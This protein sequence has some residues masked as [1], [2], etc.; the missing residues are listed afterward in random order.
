MGRDGVPEA[1]P[2]TPPLGSSDERQPG[3]RVMS[4]L[5][6]LLQTMALCQR[7]KQVFNQGIGR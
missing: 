6:R 2:D 4:L 5:L 1:R 3:E 7:Q